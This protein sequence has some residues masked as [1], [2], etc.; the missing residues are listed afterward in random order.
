MICNMHGLREK[1]K[2]SAEIVNGRGGFGDVYYRVC[3]CCFLAV[4]VTAS[5]SRTIFQKRMCAP[6]PLVCRYAAIRSHNQYINTGNPIMHNI[7]LASM[8]EEYGLF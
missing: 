8:F 7:I 3:F 2:E 1:T 4:G 5:H 6:L